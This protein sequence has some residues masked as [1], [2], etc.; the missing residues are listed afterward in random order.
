MG[1]IE[2][3]VGV[4]SSESQRLRKLDEREERNGEFR[5]GIVREV[6]ESTE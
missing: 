5:I 1:R 4:P 6:H 3:G 2:E